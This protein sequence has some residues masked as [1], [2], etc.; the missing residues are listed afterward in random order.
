[1]L[2]LNAIAEVQLA[3]LLHGPTSLVNKMLQGKGDSHRIHQVLGLG[4][5]DFQLTL[6]KPLRKKPHS[7]R[8]VEIFMGSSTE[9]LVPVDLVH[10]RP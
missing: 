1:M 3:G 6:N 8:L 4:Q 10:T 5:C 9:V 7:G 2:L